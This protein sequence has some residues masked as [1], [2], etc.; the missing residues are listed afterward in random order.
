MV[1]FYVSLLQ[2][3]SIELAATIMSN[4]FSAPNFEALTCKETLLVR[5]YTENLLSWFFKYM[6]YGRKEINAF[7]KYYGIT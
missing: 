7:C 6:K 3:H 1:S 5:F 4:V 2:Y